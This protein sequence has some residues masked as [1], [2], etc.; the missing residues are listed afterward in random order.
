M[1]P[2]QVSPRHV[3]TVVSI[4]LDGNEIFVWLSES[5]RASHGDS[6]DFER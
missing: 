6:Q 3:R 4:D 2:A 1:N 5:E